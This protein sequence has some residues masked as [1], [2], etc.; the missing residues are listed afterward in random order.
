MKAPRYLACYDNGGETADRYTVV[1]TKPMKGSHGEF[2]VY[3]GMSRDPYSPQGV[4]THGDSK[5]RIDRPT[6][7]H[8][9]KKIKFEKLPEPCRKLVL[10]DYSEFY[11]KSVY[12]KKN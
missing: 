2:F 5:E 10:E 12:A 4:G 3:V 8:L 11:P 7:N 1:F 6:G 9:G